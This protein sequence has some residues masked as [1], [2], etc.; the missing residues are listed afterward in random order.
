M[1]TDLM[2]CL[3]VHWISFENVVCLDF[4]EA[5]ISVLFIKGEE[6]I[7]KVPLS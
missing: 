2:Y 5:R 7:L 6:S 1:G 3:L 4:R